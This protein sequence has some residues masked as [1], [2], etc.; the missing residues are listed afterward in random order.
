LNINNN[1]LKNN[2]E[3]TRKNEEVIDV[4]DTESSDLDK[5]MI[6][7]NQR[8]R[9]KNRIALLKTGRLDRQTKVYQLGETPRPDPKSAYEIMERDDA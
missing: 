1:E 4:S 5:E 8:R 3:S 6:N 7:Q 9:Q 2:D